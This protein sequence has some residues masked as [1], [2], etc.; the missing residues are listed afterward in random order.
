MHHTYMHKDIH[1]YRHDHISLNYFM[2]NFSRVIM[3][4]Y[5]PQSFMFYV[6]FITVLLH[7]ITCRYIS[8]H[9]F[10]HFNTFHSAFHACQYMPLHS[11]TFHFIPITFHCNWWQSNCYHYSDEC[12]SILAINVIGCLTC[13]NYLVTLLWT[14]HAVSASTI[15]SAITLSLAPSLSLSPTRKHDPPSVN[16]PQYGHAGWTS[17]SLIPVRLRFD[18]RT[19]NV[20]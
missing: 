8:L 1:T 13:C 7:S 15:A 11:V 9:G 18:A 4:Q 19:G 17:E 3:F 12:F 2:S 6:H 14:T 5:I 16:A 20:E 10:L